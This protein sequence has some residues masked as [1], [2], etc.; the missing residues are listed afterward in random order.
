MEESLDVRRSAV[1]EAVH[2]DR[3]RR[4]VT[5]SQFTDQQPAVGDAEHGLTAALP[6]GHGSILPPT[7]TSSER[8]R[9]R[10]D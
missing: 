2:R 1:P 4:I 3:R 10:L 8:L 6:P 5:E 9:L 7:F